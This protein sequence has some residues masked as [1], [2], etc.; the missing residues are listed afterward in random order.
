MRTAGVAAQETLAP[1]HPDEGGYCGRAVG[2]RSLTNPLLPPQGDLPVLE[3]ARLRMW[4]IERTDAKDVFGYTADP[5]V[6]RYTTG[7]TPASVADIQAWLTRV[8]A[9]PETHM[10]AICL[11]GTP[12]VVGAIEFGVPSPGVG[13]VHYALAHWLWGRGLMTE[14]VKAVCGWALDSVPEMSEIRTTVVVDNPASGRVLEK[15]GFER[16]D[17]IKEVWEK[18]KSPVTLVEYYLS[19]EKATTWTTS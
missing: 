8:L 18:E 7:S 10:W 19:R 9:D 13:S 1:F 4:P 5:A 3:T 12:T 15:C 2:E 14:A 16:G 6:L 11:R 17:I